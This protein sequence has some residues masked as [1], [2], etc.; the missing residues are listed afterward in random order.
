L[1]KIDVPSELI[2]AGYRCEL[3]DTHFDQET[4]DDVWLAAVAARKWVVLTKDEKIRYRP[5][6]LQALRVAAS[7]AFIVIAGNLRGAD[8]AALL[9]RAMPRIVAVVRDTKGPFIYY[10]YKNSRVAR[11]Y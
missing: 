1:G 7:R 10:V 11:M 6:E 5:S 2:R 4:P 9:L 3:H 8:T